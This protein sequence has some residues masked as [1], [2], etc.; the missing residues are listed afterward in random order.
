MGPPF[1]TFKPPDNWWF[2]FLVLVLAYT[3]NGNPPQ[4]S[5][6]SNAPFVR[7]AHSQT[8]QAPIKILLNAANYTS[9]QPWQEA[10]LRKARA[11]GQETKRVSG[12]C[13]GKG[14]SA[15]ARIGHLRRFSMLPSD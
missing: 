11:G 15:A 12:A 4:L 9:G 6:Q 5:Y 2:G 10:P 13:T 3:E 8:Q 1:L 7:E 14:A